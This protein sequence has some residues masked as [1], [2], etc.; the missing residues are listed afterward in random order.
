MLILRRF[1]GIPV[2]IGVLLLALT[3]CE[4]GP[5]QKAGEDID[6]AVDEAGE[7]MEKAGDDIREAV[8]ADRN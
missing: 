3:G 7:A 2:V 6:D 4:K 8:G 5:A 1:F